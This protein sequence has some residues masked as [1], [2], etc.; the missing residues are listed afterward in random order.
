MGSESAALMEEESMDFFPSTETSSAHDSASFISESFSATNISTA[1]NTNLPNGSLAAAS[2]LNGGV[3]DDAASSVKK[4]KKVCM[5]VYV[6]VC[7]YVFLCVYVFVH[8]FFSYS[9]SLYCTALQHYEGT[10]RD[11]LHRVRRR[12][13][14]KHPG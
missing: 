3:K 4:R 6:W 11:G 5:C 12:V 7:V 14:Q 1:N 8:G 10:Q 9:F 2:N 13:S